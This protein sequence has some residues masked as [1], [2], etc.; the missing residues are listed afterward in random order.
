[1]NAGLRLATPSLSRVRALPADLCVAAGFYQAREQSLYRLL[2]LSRVLSALALDVK[3]SAA[4]LA[5]LLGSDED[6]AGTY[7]TFQQSTGGFRSI[8]QHTDVELMLESCTQSPA[9]M[10]VCYL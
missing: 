3:R 5:Q 1:M 8:D 9:C 4:A 2:T 10:P 7:L 6:M